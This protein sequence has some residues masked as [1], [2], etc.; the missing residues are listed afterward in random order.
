MIKIKRDDLQAA[1]FCRKG[2]MQFCDD[3][4]LDFQAMWY[5]DG[6]DVEIIEQIDDDR[7]RQVVTSARAK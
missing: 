5:G 3:N 6:V 1:G 4:G 2:V 7:A